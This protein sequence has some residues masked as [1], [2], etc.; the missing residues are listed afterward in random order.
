MPEEK[1]TVPEIDLTKIRNIDA[2]K[3]VEPDFEKRV[4]EPAKRNKSSRFNFSVVETIPLPSRGILYT[5]VTED[6]DI[7]NGKIKM[8]PMTLKEEKVLS[9][10]RFLKNGSATRIILDRCIQSNISAKDI[11]L[12][13][14]NFLMFY[15]RKISYGDEY[16]FNITCTNSVCE[17]K[18][19]HTVRIS[20]LV[21]EELP[22]D[23]TE[24]IIVKL[25]ISKYTI[26][27]VLPRL[28]H[29]EELAQKNAMRKKSSSDEDRRLL[30]NFL[31]TTQEV[32]DDKGE[33]VP[34]G[35]WEEFYDALPGLDVATIR[36]K[37]TISTGVDKLEN[38]VCPYCE[39]EFSGTIPIGPEFF[40]F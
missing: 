30:D 2:I 17:K 38:V 8:S 11:L 14:S 27:I 25:P 28:F 24:P 34:R 23:F 1:K 5:S 15:L 29:T 32:I 6:T 35:Y 3:K 20:D 21:F 10:T 4:I 22:E 37:T 40:R 36:E 16:T 9:T 7:L 39:T 18:F 13:D 12:F 33:K 19:D 26:H 31:I